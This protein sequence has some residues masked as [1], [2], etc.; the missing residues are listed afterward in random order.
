MKL[1]KT[2]LSKRVLFASR[3]ATDKHGLEPWSALG[4]RSRPC[5]FSAQ[6]FVTDYCV[7]KRLKWPPRKRSVDRR[8]FRQRKTE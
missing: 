1:Q 3:H 7:F 8:T 5:D 6:D 2:L 4:A